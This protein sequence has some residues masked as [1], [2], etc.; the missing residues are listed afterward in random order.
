MMVVVVLVMM[1]IFY[2]HFFPNR[3]P[4]FLPNLSTRR[5]EISIGI[6][7]RIGWISFWLTGT[8]CSFHVGTWYD[9][10]SF[11]QTCFFSLAHTFTFS[12]LTISIFFSSQNSF[13]SFSQ[14]WCFSVCHSCTWIWIPW[15]NGRKKN[16]E[17]IRNVPIPLSIAASSRAPILVVSLCATPFSNAVSRSFS[18]ATNRAWHIP[19]LQHLCPS[20][21]CPECPSSPNRAP[22]FV[23]NRPLDAPSILALSPPP[24]WRM[25]IRFIIIIAYPSNP[26]NLVRRYSHWFI[27]F[28]PFGHFDFF[29]CGNFT[30][31]PAIGKLWCNSRSESYYVCV[32]SNYASNQIE[33]QIDFFSPR[34][35]CV[36]YTHTHVV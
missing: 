29:P 22:K 4:D 33:K 19:S 16:I 14:I 30:F 31:L 20:I 36:L 27:D 35:H 21:S 5:N 25:Q 24:N 8:L 28:L 1:V 18:S 34:Y 15:E 2:P 11:F 9:F 3:F 13:F 6:C 17:S 12:I 23:S 10:H 7:W 32:M 26:I